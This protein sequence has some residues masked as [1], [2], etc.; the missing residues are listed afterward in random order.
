MRAHM[1]LLV[2]DDDPAWVE[3]I[4]LMLESIYD[5]E[6]ATTITEA[7]DLLRHARATSSHFDAAIVDQ[8]IRESSGI[9]VIGELRLLQPGL[10][11]IVLTGY[12]AFEAALEA[13]KAGAWCYVSKGEPN[14]THRLREAVTDALAQNPISSFVKL[15]E[16]PHVEFKSSARWDI[17]QNKSNKVMEEVIVKT[18]ASF[19]NSEGGGSL[20]IGVDDDG[21]IVGLDADYSSLSRKNRDGFE[22]FLTTL[23]GGNLGADTLFFVRVQFHGVEGK[24]VCLVSVMPSSRPVYTG[25][26]VLY[27]R[28][29]NSSRPLSTREAVAYCKNRWNQ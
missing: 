17:R 20:L 4:K 29:G 25:G 21:N 27:V 3:T 5:L 12:P 26:D 15:G 24:D 6:I 2:I 28:F 9:Q 8:R 7:L 23:L 18:V 13:G 10:P 1:R 19:L 16:G 11:C 22:N 14:L